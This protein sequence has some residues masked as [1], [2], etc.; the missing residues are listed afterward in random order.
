MNLTV[1]IASVFAALSPFRSTAP[2]RT[3]S[4][5]EAVEAA[6]SEVEAITDRVFE[7]TLGEPDIKD[8]GGYFQPDWKVVVPV[9][10]S[11]Y[12][13]PG[14]LV[15]DLPR[16][17]SDDDSLLYVLMDAV[18]ADEIAD[19]NGATVP[20]EIVGGNPMVLWDAVRADDA[21]D[22]ELA[23]AYKAA[24]ER[25]HEDDVPGWEDDE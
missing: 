15:F 4:G 10:A 25:D 21:D 3:I 22:E 14:S 2:E 1:A 11:D 6:I 16:G 13:D 5:A 18:G 9:S 23:E 19:I 8:F 24:A 12:E 17:R 20:M 7:A